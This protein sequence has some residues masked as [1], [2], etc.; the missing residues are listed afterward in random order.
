MQANLWENSLTKVLEG[1]TCKEK[2]RNLNDF[3]N[4]KINEWD[5]W[6][7]TIQDGILKRTVTKRLLPVLAGQ[8][9]KILT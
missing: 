9:N 8:V 6:S 5:A 4:G 7:S 3:I 2:K 1:V